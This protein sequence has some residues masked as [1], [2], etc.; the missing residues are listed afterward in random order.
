MKRCSTCHRK[1]AYIVTTDHVVVMARLKRHAR[2]AVTQSGTPVT[3]YT[4]LV[5]TPSGDAIDARGAATAATAAISGTRRRYVYASD[6]RRT[7]GTGAGSGSGESG[8]SWTSLARRVYSSGPGSMGVVPLA[9]CLKSELA[10]YTRR[11]ARL[12]L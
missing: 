2:N 11:R 8:A 12:M 4:P 9:L 3:S 10:R 6:D 7:V 1:C 5:K